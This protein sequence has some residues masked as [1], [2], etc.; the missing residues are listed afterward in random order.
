MAYVEKLAARDHPHEVYLF[1][2]G[3]STYD[4]DEDVH[5]QRTIL[6]FLARNVAG[7]SVPGGA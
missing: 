4:I 7:V 5:Q 3:H 1:G 6:D 2:T